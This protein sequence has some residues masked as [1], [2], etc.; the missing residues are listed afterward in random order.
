MVGLAGYTGMLKYDQGIV[1]IA[2]FTLLA[3]IQL[4]RANGMEWWNRTL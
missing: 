3:T 2:T 4:P 1:V